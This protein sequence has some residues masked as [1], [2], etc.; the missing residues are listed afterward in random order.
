MPAPMVYAPGVPR[1]TSSAPVYAIV[2]DNIREV[3]IAATLTR[4]AESETTQR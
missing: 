3:K 4:T 2:H 1:K